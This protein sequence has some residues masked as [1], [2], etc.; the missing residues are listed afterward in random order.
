MFHKLQPLTEITLFSLKKS[1]D[2]ITC[3]TELDV[4]YIA[5]RRHNPL[6][7]IHLSC[8]IYTL[9]WCLGLENPPTLSVFSNKLL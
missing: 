9:V 5:D 8:I 1:F 4:L 6:M 7:K 2:H 3:C